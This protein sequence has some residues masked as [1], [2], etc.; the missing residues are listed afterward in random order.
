MT[1]IPIC[2][3]G[4]TSLCPPADQTLIRYSH[5]FDDI[6]AQKTPLGVMLLRLLSTRFDKLD[7]IPKELEQNI[8]K[9]RFTAVKSVQ[10][11]SFEGIGHALF[12][13]I[14]TFLDCFDN[15]SIKAEIVSTKNICILLL[16]YSFPS[17]ASKTVA[18]ITLVV[19]VNTKF[20]NVN[21]MTLSLIFLLRFVPNL[22]DDYSSYKLLDKRL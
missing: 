19:H 10:S 17:L 13:L 14:R 6:Y 12:I 5:E 1:R 2:N 8:K 15:N 4:R 7:S 22:N 21:K 20:K 16:F 18:Y 11:M 9:S 3:D